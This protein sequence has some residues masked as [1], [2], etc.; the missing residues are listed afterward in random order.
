M[1][2]TSF[3]LTFPPTLNLFSI[4][5]QEFSLLQENRSLLR[6]LCRVLVTFSIPTAT[7]LNWKGDWMDRLASI[8]PTRRK[9]LNTVSPVMQT[10]SSHYL[11]IPQSSSLCWRTLLTSY[12]LGFSLV[13]TDSPLLSEL[14]LRGNATMYMSLITDFLLLLLLYMSSSLLYYLTKILVMASSWGDV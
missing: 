9:W 3:S 2:K 8:C 1:S 11:L 14:S 12:Q 13:Y 5:P 6:T 4:F 10:F 7:K